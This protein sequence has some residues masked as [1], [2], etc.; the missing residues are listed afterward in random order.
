MPNT[1]LHACLKEDKTMR[2]PDT[3][4]PLTVYIAPFNWYEQSKQ[5]D[6]YM[7]TKMV[8]D[9]MQI[10][11]EA[12]DGKVRF[13]QVSNLDQSQIDVKWRRVDR[14]SLGHCEYNWN[15]EGMIFS[16]EIQIGISDGRVHG[17]Y[18]DPKEVSHTIIHE[19]GHALGILGHSDAPDDIMYVPHQYGVTAISE[20]DAET[21]RYL[22]RLPIGF[23]PHEAAQRLNIPAPYTMDQV[24]AAALG[25]GEQPTPFAQTLQDK[26]QHNAEVFNEAKLD[27]QHDILS[28]Q[29][30]FLMATQNIQI[31]QSLKKPPSLT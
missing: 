10:W 7:Y 24:V 17:A 31:P 25:E 29:G 26:V 30:Q 1:Y 2:W 6:A 18:N 11:T 28:Q 5:Q 21:L 14:K 16:A 22:Y 9:A 4:M 3:A 23:N 15:K 27:E 13:Q 20:R 19:F 12:S 8:Q